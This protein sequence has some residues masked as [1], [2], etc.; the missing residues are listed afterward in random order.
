[1]LV[2][3]SDIAQWRHL[4]ACEPV[5]AGAATV[6]EVPAAGEHLRV[7]KPDIIN[8]DNIIVLLFTIYIFYVVGTM[9]II[10]AG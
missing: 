10:L 5:L 7:Q 9:A 6:G 1:M 8:I 4:I 3:L 2:C